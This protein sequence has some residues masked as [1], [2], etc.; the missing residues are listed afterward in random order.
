K[1]FQEFDLDG[2]NTISISELEAVL[3]QIGL[4]PPMDIVYAILE[5]IDMDRSGDIDFDEFCAL[6]T[7][8]LGPD[9]KV[10]IER[11]LRSM[12]DSMSYE[13]KQRKA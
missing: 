2:S 5:A 12:F 1:T 4:D 9:G 3:Q 11:M 6:L 7:R 8:M 13:A 10:D